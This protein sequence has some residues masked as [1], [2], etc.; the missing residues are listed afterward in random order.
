[1]PYLGSYEVSTAHIPDVSSD[2][3]VSIF[4]PKFFSEKKELP[5]FFRNMINFLNVCNVLN[6]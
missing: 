1:M 2:L 6:S 4:R 5:F 3:G